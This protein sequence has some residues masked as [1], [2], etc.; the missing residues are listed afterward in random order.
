[1]YAFREALGGGGREDAAQKGASG[2]G[3][4]EE[5]RRGMEDLLQA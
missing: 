1:M 4:R 3:R 5:E 2:I